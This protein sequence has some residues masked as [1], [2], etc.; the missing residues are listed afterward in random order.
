MPVFLYFMQ[1]AATA[2]LDEGCV[3]PP[4]DLNLQT[5]APEAEHANLTTTPLGWLHVLPFF[6]SMF[7]RTL[8]L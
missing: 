7:Q 4:Q 6:K 3:G 2:W 1:D 8:V 5:Q